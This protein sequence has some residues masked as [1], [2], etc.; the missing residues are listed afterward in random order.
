MYSN[1]N[2]GISCLKSNGNAYSDGASKADILNWHFASVFSKEL[3]FSTRDPFGPSSY[4][5]MAPIYIYENGV[6]NV[7]L[8][9]LAVRVHFFIFISFVYFFCSLYFVYFCI[10]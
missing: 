7:L 10:L 1:D 8:L 9:L 3:D 5:D 2:F 6:S 4:P